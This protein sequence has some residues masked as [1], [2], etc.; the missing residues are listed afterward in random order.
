MLRLQRFMTTPPKLIAGQKRGEK[1]FSAI[2]LTLVLVV[3]LGMMGL[4]VDAGR[5][6]ICKNELQ[7]FVDASAMAAISHMD[8]TQNG[9][10]TANSMATAGPL[11]ASQPNG[12]N[13]GTTTISTV[14]NTFATTYAGTYDS[15]GTADGPSTNTYRFIRV[16]ASANVPLN[17]LPVIPG[18]STSMTMTASA[19]AGQNPSS[20]VG[21]GGLLPFA[22]DAHNQADK[23]NFGLTPGSVY[24]L[25]WGNGNTTTCAGDAGFTPPGSP[26]SEHGFID[27]G[28]GN[29][30][31]NVRTAIRWG[32]YPNA[33]ST[34]SS[35]ST[36]DTLGGVPGNR[37]SSIFDALNDRAQEDTDDVSAT[38][39]AYMAAG[40]GNGR[41]VVTVAMAGTWSGNGS[42]ASTPNLGF[43]NFFLLP[44][45]SGTSGPICAIY[46]GP[47][48]LTGNAAATTD[49]TKVY[50]D[51]LYQ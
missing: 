28:E 26:P 51:M 30:N 16:T 25:K 32:G 15:Y 48:N 38:Y 8:G 10:T 4:A 49:S 45:Y 33:N 17:F 18:I 13:F 34:P 22:P 11:G 29:S 12:Y 42:N 27:I 24:T 43:A 50:T 40:T 21:D 5:M 39:A 20:T 35:I 14:T 23:V 7:T 46:I 47:G 36:G 37:G 31:S 9:I 19:T 2:L 44:S 6:F 1:G 41:R 3:M